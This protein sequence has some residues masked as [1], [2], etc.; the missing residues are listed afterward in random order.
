ME[1]N[2]VELRADEPYWL[3]NIA[4]K[5]TAAYNS[6]PSYKVFRNVKDFG[7]KGDGFTDDTVAINLAISTGNRCGGG[8]CPSSTTT[9]ALVYF[10]RGTYIVS[11]PIIA[12]YYTQLIGDAKSPPTLLASASFVGMAI[13][14]ADPY[15][16]G[17]GGRQWYGNTNN[18]FR[19]VRNFVIDTRRMPA[20][21]TGT[22]IHWQVAQA[23]SLF[24]IVFY[25]SAAYNT[26]HQ[27]LFIENGSGGYMGDLTFSG[28]KYGMWVGNQQFTVR[29]VVINNAQTAVYMQWNWGWTF[30]RI[31]VNNC[32]V[33]FDLFTSASTQG[34]GALA[35]IDADI[36]NTPIFLR[37]AQSSSTNLTGSLALE[38]IDLINVPIAVSTSSGEVILHGGTKLIDSWVQGNVYAGADSNREYIRESIHPTSK[39]ASLTT[40]AGKIFGKMHPQY[41]TL[42]ASDIVSIKDCGAKGDGKTDDTLA[43]QAA[44]VK[45]AG[46]K[47]VFFDSGTYIV[48]KGV[49]VPPGSRLV[50]EAWSVIAG[51]GPA[52]SEM[53]FPRPVVR[54][55]AKGSQGIV[56]ISDIIFTTIGPAPGAIVIEWNIREPAGQQGS[57]G[58]WDTHIRLGGAAGTNL[59]YPQCPTRG[60]TVANCMAAYLALHLT[61]G[62]S[63]Y[64]EG[65]WIWLADH[66][67]DGSS[68]AQISVYAGRGILSESK[69]PVWMIGTAE[70]FVLYQYRLVNAENHYLG[71]IQTESPYFQPSPP[72]PAPFE[73]TKAYKDP[74]FPSDVKSAWGLSVENSRDIIVFG[75]GLYSF[76]NNY[77][78]A[79]I[80]KRNCQAKIMDID[81]SSKISVFSLS[82]VA[83]TFQVSLDGKGVVDQ[84]DNLNGFAS[85]VTLWRGGCE[86]I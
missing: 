13:I 51:T 53:D 17:G 86:L 69:G 84:G 38:N 21:N 48:R 47:V 3:E 80:S 61:E 79:C 85:T 30:Q 57:A 23:T 28:G 31:Q 74:S 62:S 78:Q 45:Y 76:F 82:T 77:S 46:S 14:D 37:T 10:P 24:N 42:R 52:Y 58:M 19:S 33:G 35:I 70:H 29:N 72:A 32:K 6:D 55:G 15:I 12:Y 54:V 83:S 9:P 25:L 66:D 4:H 18:F 44:L 75:A 39:P 81:S 43:I 26:A 7:A 59:Q 63:A 1:A 50:G 8:N 65:S 34:V 49:T 56:E 5:G 73:I 36:T 68:E 16:E 11:S 20:Q 41:E 60:G 67:L 40:P 22:G 2:A 64:L 71:L 27:G